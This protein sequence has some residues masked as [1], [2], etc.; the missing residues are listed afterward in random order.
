MGNG[1]SKR[2]LSPS[3]RSG[4]H[5][6]AEP[7]WHSTSGPRAAGPC[8]AASTASR[9]TLEEKHRFPNPNGRLNGHLHWNLLGPV[10]GAQD[11][12]AQ[13]R[14]AQAAHDVDGI[15]V[16]TWGVDFGFLD[17]NGDLLGQPLHVPRP[18]HRRHDGTA[19]A[20]VAASR[21]LR[22]HRHP[23]HAAQHALP[24][25]ARCAK[26]K[27]PLLDLAETLLFMPDL[28]NYL[29]TGDEGAEFS[30]R[31]APARCSTRAAATGRTACS[32]SSACRPHFLPTIVPPARVLGPSA[33]RRRRRVRRRPRSR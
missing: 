33:R 16:D 9:L 24:A 29:F 25:P 31:H 18:P 11:R 27:S 28:F 26:R 30:D 8:S 22:G 5:G 10:G 3:R 15:G 14:P 6:G 21:D 32:S 19:F 12:P 4:N 13:G 2:L 1:L 20:R 17:Q 7:C 23:V